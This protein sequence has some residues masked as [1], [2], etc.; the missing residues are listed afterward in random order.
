MPQRGQQAVGGAVRPVGG[1]RGAAAGNNNFVRPQGKGSSAL[2]VLFSRR[3][4][5]AGNEKPLRVPREALHAR[6]AQ[7]RNPK[8][9]RAQQK[10]VLHHGGLQRRGIYPA[11][12]LLPQG[13]AEGREKFPELFV[14]YPPQ[15]F[16]R[17]G[18]VPEIRG[19]ARIQNIAAPVARDAELLERLFVALQHRNLRAALRRGQCRRKPR[20]AAADHRNPHGIPSPFHYSGC[21]SPCQT[22][23]GT[24]SGAPR[25]CGKPSGKPYGKKKSFCGAFE[26]NSPD[27]LRAKG[28]RTAHAVGAATGS[29]IIHY[30]WY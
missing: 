9:P 12:L 19:F 25:G 28:L 18:R 15:R 23:S 3:R 21:A 8:L 14:A 24:P 27:R 26:D 10:R 17:K 1:R 4:P 2:R 6:Q 22:V 11:L 16:P 29:S 13:N 30:I 7:N 20:R 5:Q